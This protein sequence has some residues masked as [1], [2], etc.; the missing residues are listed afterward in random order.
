VNPVALEA[1]RYQAPQFDVGETVTIG[2]LVYA[3]AYFTLTEVPPVC[4]SV[5]VCAV[6]VPAT[7]G[8]PDTYVNTSTVLLVTEATVATVEAK[9]EPADHPL[10]PKLTV[11]PIVKPSVEDT[12]NVPVAA[13][14]ATTTLVATM[15]DGA[16]ETEPDISA[17]YP[18]I[19]DKAK[20]PAVLPAALVPIATTPAALREMPVSTVPN[21]EVVVP[22]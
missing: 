17:L 5:P 6:Y 21:A 8:P 2:M 7:Q 20:V 16:D 3:V 1:D 11:S 9:P 10:A 22:H 12:V 4:A 14:T 18:F 15:P 19:L 13:P